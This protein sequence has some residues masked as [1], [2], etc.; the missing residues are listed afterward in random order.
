MF[1]EKVPNAAFVWGVDAQEALDSGRFYPGDSWVDWV[2]LHIYDRLRDGAYEFDPL[3]TLDYFYYTYQKTKPIMI[4][5]LAVSHYTS[6]DHAYRNEAAAREIARLYQK[7]AQDYPRVKLVNYMDINEVASG[8]G[9]VPAD[10][11]LLTENSSLLDAYRQAVSDGHFL[12]VLDG[13]GEYALQL[14]KSP[15][16]VLKKDGT[17]FVSASSF[18]YDLNTQGL[19]GEIILNGEKYY[20]LNRYLKNGRRSLISAEENHKIILALNAA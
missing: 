20:D 9:D 11:F 6:Q 16:P 1:R 19:T 15:F 4:S 8:A 13:G 7:I 10:N 2:S 18:Q 3:N 17:W 12:S 14:M 5:Q